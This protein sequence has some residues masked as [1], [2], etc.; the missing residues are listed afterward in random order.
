VAL[1]SLKLFLTLSQDASKE[2][3]VRLKK[4]VMISP[5]FLALWEKIKGRTAYRVQL[6]ESQLKAQCLTELSHSERVT[7]AKIVSRTVRMNVEQ[8]GVTHTE[9]ELRTADI[10]N[11]GHHLPEFLRMVDNECFLS[12]RTVAELLVE[13][14]RVSDF[15]NN[16]Q[17]MTEVFI[18]ALRHVQGAMEIDG[19]RYVK[20]DGEEYYLQEIFD[21]A[22]LTAFLDRNAIAV[23]RSVYDHIIYDSS[24]VERPFAVALDSDPDVRMFFKIPDKFKIETP[25]GNYNPDWAVYMDK[26]GEQRLYFVL[27]TK[28][29]VRI[30]DLRTPE[31]QK[32]HCGEAHFAALTNGVELRVARDWREF[33]MNV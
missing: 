22:E 31:Q 10:D 5:E 27:E 14:E 23:D 13:S 15:L 26:D 3:R 30:G 20:L 11:E 21:S 18:E 19:I 16:P 12:Q 29:T 25:I 4:E 17:R 1:I 33:K 8:S 24:T 6:D 32:I 9:T 28:G 7:K 2:V